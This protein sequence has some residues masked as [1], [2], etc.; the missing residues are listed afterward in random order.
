MT[1]LQ[2]SKFS[3]KLFLE[4]PCRFY[5]ISGNKAGVPVYDRFSSVVAHELPLE[6]HKAGQRAV[7]QLENSQFQT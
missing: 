4:I 3:W 2:F 6:V 7:V 5:E 1:N